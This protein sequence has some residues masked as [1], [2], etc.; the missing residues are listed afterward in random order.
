M[1]S[2][3]IDWLTSQWPLIIAIV[4]GVLSLIGV[5]SQMTSRSKSWKTLSYFLIAIGGILTIAAATGTTLQQSAHE[6]ESLIKT[7]ELLSLTKLLQ[8]RT[9]ELLEQG[10][11]VN[12]LTETVANKNYEIGQQ[13]ARITEL[14][15]DSLSWTTGGDN[16]CYFQFPIPNPKSNTIDLVLMTY[17][18][19]PVYDVQVKIADVEGRI[20]ALE[21][22]TQKGTLPVESVVDA[23]QLMSLGSKVIPVGT[24]APQILVPIGKLNL[25]DADKQS[26]QMDIWARNGHAVQLLTYRRV[27]DVWKGAMRTYKRDNTVKEDIEPG[28]PRNEKGE[29]KW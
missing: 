12:R 10:K 2:F 9:D 16:F 27:N 19:H 28:F 5:I 11:R 18:K 22:E 21:R 15:Q 29:V 6:E 3:G 4:G 17:G 8:V 20:A 26:F 7:N 25:P 23:M 1:L 24:M 14:V 13:N